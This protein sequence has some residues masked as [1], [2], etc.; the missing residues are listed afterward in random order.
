MKKRGDAREGAD[1]APPATTPTVPTSGVTPAPAVAV[2]SHADTAVASR[3][4]HMEAMTPPPTGNATTAGVGP[5]GAA[6]AAASEPVEGIQA[7]ESTDALLGVVLEQRYEIVRKIGQGGMGAVYE[8]THKLLG[9]RVAVKVLLD[10]YAQKDQIVARLEQEARLASSIGHANIIDITDFGQ[11][12]DGRTFVV[13]EFLEGESLGALI[14]RSGRLDPHRAIGISRQVASA[15]GSAHEKG[16]VHRDIKP[17]NVFLLRRGEEDFVKVVDFG[18]SKS[19]KPES[20]EDSPRLTQTGMVLGTPLYMSPEQARGDDELDHR[21]DV[22]ALGVILYEMVTAEVPFRGSNYLNILSQVLSDEPTPPSQ[23]N[24]DVSPDLEAVILKA[25][26]KDRAERYQS[27]EEMGADLSALHADSMAATGARLTANRRRKRA[28]RRSALRTM[29]W[30]AGI[31]VIAAAVVIMV[32]GSGDGERKPGGE[33]APSAGV[34][35]EPATETPV[36]PELVPPVVPPRQPAVEVA[37]IA[38]QSSPSGVEV[39]EGD[40]QLGVTPFEWRWEKIN[41]DIVLTGEK[42]GYD[43]ATITINPFLNP[44]QPAVLRLKKARSGSGK[45]PE[46]RRG[47]EEAA[48]AP[49]G[50]RDDTAGGDL[51]G[52]PYRT[53][54]KP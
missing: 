15:L 32:R 48:P 7:G 5:V 28:V 37:T 51:T 9:K 34:A 14:A 6:H 27:M 12:I 35:A 40:R 41:R 43:Y 24:P 21:I 46:R 30:V 18:I 17:E 54:G 11:T 29:L 25:L 36:V 52:S 42:N 2:D 13:M 16:I 26:E 50:S 47:G 10:K 19:L 4:Q 45:R 1:G 8:A 3:S 33:S 49:A 39:F 23:L 20:G 22:Y 44:D 53:K 31:S 38:I